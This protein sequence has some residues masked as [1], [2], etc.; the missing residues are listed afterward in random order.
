[1]LLTLVFI[2]LSTLTVLLNLL[3][4]ILV[5][6]NQDTQIPL[7]YTLTPLAPQ[8]THPLILSQKLNMLL[9]DLGLKIDLNNN[10]SCPRL[11]DQELMKEYL[12]YRDLNSA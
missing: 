9:G 7:S 6:Q 3:P 2:I 12:R 8:N 5:S 1:M 11:L 4:L 10:S